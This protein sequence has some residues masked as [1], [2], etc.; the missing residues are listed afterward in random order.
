[1]NINLYYPNNRLDKIFTISIPASAN[2]IGLFLFNYKN[3][4]SETIND[5]LDTRLV[6][7]F[8]TS[9][10][11][12]DMFLRTVATVPRGVFNAYVVACVRLPFV[13]ANLLTHYAFNANLG[14]AVVQNETEAQVWHVMSARKGFEPASIARVTGVSVTVDDAD[15]YYPKELICM[16][17]NV[18]AE[19]IKCMDASLPD[20]NVLQA[21]NFLYP[22]VKINHEDVTIHYDRRQKKRI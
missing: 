19:L 16:Q 22:H 7:G 20:K 18:P 2:S 13:A 12:V 8:E 6:S 1:M 17:G 5:N 14:L 3:D 15:R 11:R 9:R 4:L 21:I 10:R